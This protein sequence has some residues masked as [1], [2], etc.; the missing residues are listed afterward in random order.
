MKFVGLC[1]SVIWVLSAVEFAIVVRITGY[2][3]SITEQLVGP[4]QFWKHLEWTKFR[5][6]VRYV[7]R[8]HFCM[9]CCHL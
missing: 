8:R 1:L 6:A 5:N 7:M 2:K 9:L 4:E 3:T